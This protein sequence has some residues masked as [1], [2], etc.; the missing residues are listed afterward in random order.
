MII[1]AIEEPIP[2]LEKLKKS[3]P[4]GYMPSQI[5]LAFHTVPVNEAIREVNG[6]SRKASSRER[7]HSPYDSIQSADGDQYRASEVAGVQARSLVATPPPVEH[8][9]RGSVLLQKIGTIT[10][11]LPVSMEAL[12]QS[13]HIIPEWLPQACLAGRF[14]VVATKKEE[15]TD[16]KAL[17]RVK[18]GQ[19]KEKAPF[20]AFV[21]VVCQVFHT[22]FS[23]VLQYLYQGYLLTR[24]QG[25]P[26]LGR[27]TKSCM[28]LCEE[29]CEQVRNVCRDSGEKNQENPFSWCVN[30]CK[31]M[32]S[33]V[34]AWIFG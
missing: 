2:E 26:L 33:W 4:T 1:E 15:R 8:N 3:V 31:E 9:A 18:K 13:L 32:V 23:T 7:G 12:L 34:K 19:K 29:A 25:I 10:A 24:D 30:K 11:R 21:S 20:L 22:L 28:D 6:V 14:N 16:N 27:V 5:P 17:E